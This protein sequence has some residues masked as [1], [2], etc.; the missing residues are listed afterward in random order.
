VV[1]VVVLLLLVLEQLVGLVL[2]LVVAP[3]PR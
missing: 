2:E 1:L 3:V